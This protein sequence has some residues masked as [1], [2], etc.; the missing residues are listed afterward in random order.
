MRTHV[1]HTSWAK[2]NHPGSHD[3]HGTPDTSRMHATCNGEVK[4]A[5][6]RPP[7]TGPSGTPGTASPEFTTRSMRSRHCASCAQQSSGF[8]TISKKYR[9][10]MTLHHIYVC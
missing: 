10:F 3:L 9:T 5:H 8:I 4:R 2:G 6:H 1:L 7:V